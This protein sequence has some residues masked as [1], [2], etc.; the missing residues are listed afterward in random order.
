VSQRYTLA[1]EI[2]SEQ[3][4]YTALWTTNARE[5]EV[6]ARIAASLE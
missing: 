5:E 4:G 2:G 1:D 6:F 3:L